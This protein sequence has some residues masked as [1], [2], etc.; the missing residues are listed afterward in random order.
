MEILVCCHTVIIICPC[1]V[2]HHHYYWKIGTPRCE[3]I[4]PLEKHIRNSIQKKEFSCIS[5]ILIKK[6]FK[7]MIQKKGRAQIFK[8]GVA[9]CPLK[10][11][12]PPPQKKKLEK[13][14]G[15]NQMCNKAIPLFSPW[16]YWESPI[17]LSC[18]PLF[19]TIFV[20]IW[21]PLG[22]TLQFIT[23]GY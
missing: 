14:Q 23:S 7:V 17:A 20:F 15:A 3:R 16:G 9:W 2:S 19:K 12:L 22:P 6:V 10:T 4:S 5:R 11:V 21:I 8:W 13:V 1:Y 18:M